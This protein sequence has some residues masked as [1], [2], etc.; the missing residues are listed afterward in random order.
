MM[1]RHT[2]S[3]AILPDRPNFTTTGNQDMCEYAWH[4]WEHPEYDQRVLILDAT[5]S[6]LRRGLPTS[7][8]ANLFPGRV[9]LAGVTP[10]FK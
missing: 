3:L 7:V 5:D 8:Y 10:L 6:R 4:L 1:Q 9:E 2:P